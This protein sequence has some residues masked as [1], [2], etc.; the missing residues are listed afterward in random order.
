MPPGA[1]G[2]FEPTLTGWVGH[3]AAAVLGALFG[4]FANVCI[5]RWPPTDEH[6][7]G[8]SVVRPGSH[9]P[10]CGGAIRW[11]DNIPVVSYF[12]L[13]GRCR[14]CGASFSAR[15][16][17]VEAATAMLFAAVYHLEVVLLYPADVLPLRLTRFA[18][19]A[20]FV[21][22]LVVIS[23]IDLDTKLILN[24]ITYPAIPIFWGLGL[25]LPERAWYHGL[26]GAA[27]GY[28]IIRLV[29][30]GYYLVTRRRGLGYGDGKLLAL[31]GAYLG[32]QAV[33]FALFLGS[34]LGA[35]IGGAALAWSRASA[36]PSSPS[37]PSSVEGAPEPEPPQPK[38]RHVEIPFGPFLAAAALA[39]LFLEPWLRFRFWLLYN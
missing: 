12:A 37:S 13:G 26:V 1:F 23:F 31:V 22:A 16:A 33:M 19:A 38:L 15:Y 24:R 3:V 10:R 4:S 14:A 39:Y 34:I 28:G 35:V 29:A 30:D 21:L 11:Y 27:L 9:C 2:A 20:A 6:P 17:L 36:E 32:W 7:D 25:L 18:I 5:V 8:R